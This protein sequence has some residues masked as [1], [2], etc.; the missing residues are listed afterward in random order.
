MSRSRSLRA[1][2]M[3]RSA[4]AFCPRS[5][6]LARGLGKWS[7]RLSPRQKF[8]LVL[9]GDHSV[10]IGTVAGI[11]RA[12]RDE[13]REDR[14]DLDRCA[15]GYEHS[16]NLAERQ[17]SRH[18]A[19]LLHRPRA[20]GT[21]RTFSASLRRSIPRMSRS[22]GLRDVDR[23]EVP[24]VRDAGVAAFTMREIDERGLRSVMTEAI[25]RASDGTTGFHLSFDMDAVDPAE[26]PG[27]GTP[28]RGG[29]TYREAHL[30]MEIMCDCA[31]VVGMEIVEV[32]PVLDRRTGP[33]YW[34]LS[35]S[36]RHWE[37]GFC[38]D[39]KLPYCTADEA[40]STRSRSVPPN[41]L[42]MRSIRN[43]TKWF[44]IFISKEGKWDPRPILPEPGGNPGIDVVFPA[45][46]GTFG[47]DG[48]VQGLLELADLP[49]VG[50]GVL[51]SSAAMDKEVTK[52]LCVQAGLP[53]VEY[54]VVHG[55][56]FDAA[57]TRIALRLSDVRET[58]EPRVVRRHLEGQ[59]PVG[60]RSRHRRR[61][62]IRS[63]G[64]RGTRDR[65]P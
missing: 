55:G 48:T 20:V 61:V 42:S 33:R 63:Q 9:G 18:A 43:D 2:P 6:K 27:V 36:C 56:A 46:H 31:K 24:Y 19:R 5:R 50:P 7:T 52:R 64:H 39:V 34:E 4:R 25:E 11:A 57:G 41:R 37:R 58:G 26:A 30:L 45:L 51:A 40:E 14:T 12:Y 28:V 54:A 35:W 60:S 8:P 38:E 16:G 15:R 62:P 22:S 59:K 29:L 21:D 10:A 44:V 53:V 1:T 65:R 3:A 23:T 17:C 47:E 49:Y 32:N 13:R